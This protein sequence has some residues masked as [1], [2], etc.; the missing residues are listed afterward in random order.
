M[1]AGCEL[2]DKYHVASVCVKPCHVQLEAKQ[3]K[4]SD[5]AVGTVIGFPHGSHTTATKA[6][7]TREATENGAVELDMVMN[8]GEF[9][10]GHY[11]YV[12]NDIKAVV[13]I[14]RG[15]AIVKVIL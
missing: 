4:G 2:A 3:L 8:I 5:V 7:E 13:D 9:L 14:A 12:R 15:Q 1:I 6:A 11:D 10:S